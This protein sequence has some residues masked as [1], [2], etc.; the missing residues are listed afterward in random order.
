MK[1][2]FGGVVLVVVLVITTAKGAPL[3]LPSGLNGPVECKGQ[4]FCCIHGTLDSESRRCVC[5]EGW[6]GVHCL[7]CASNSS[8]S[9][10]PSS[11]SSSSSSGQ[12]CDNSMRVTHS[13]SFNCTI[14]LGMFRSLLMGGYLT[15]YCNGSSPSS[16]DVWKGECGMQ[17][18]DRYFVTNW[19]F[20]CDFLH[21]SM[22]NLNSST[23]AYHCQKTQCVCNE[24]PPCN[25]ILHSILPTMIGWTVFQCDSKP[26][27]PITPHPK[28]FKKTLSVPIV[29]KHSCRFKQQ[30]LLGGEFAGIHCASGECLP[31]PLP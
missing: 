26:S 22:R 21:C 31:S 12:V 18:W 5:E 2:Y 20:Y 27:Q 7:D 29:A 1:G 28:L 8:C 25:Y 24:H 10:G 14:D 30:Q 11:S 23:I 6:F 15:W 13:K 16:H 17:L 3:S 4:P 9:H 19:Y